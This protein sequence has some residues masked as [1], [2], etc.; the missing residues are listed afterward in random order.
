VSVSPTGREE[1]RGSELEGIPLF[2]TLA[3]EDRAR[4][5]TA[6]R[7]LVWD[8]GNVVVNEG[9]FAFDCYVIMRGAA[10]VRRTGECLAV[11]GAGDVFG[12]LGVVPHGGER[13][14]RRRNASVVVTEPTV[15][16]A[17]PGGEMRRLAE[18]IPALGGGLRSAAAERTRGETS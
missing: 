3:V 1:I 10:E 11:L 6:A 17:I 8:V 9:E 4:I 5:A 18:E 16:V 15:A 13:W 2:A 12:E 7:K 14:S